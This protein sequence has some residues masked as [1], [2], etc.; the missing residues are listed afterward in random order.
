MSTFTAVI[1]YLVYVYFIPTTWFVY[2]IHH[3][4]HVMPLENGKK[5][6]GKNNLLLGFF[7]KIALGSSS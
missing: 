3:G 2:F 7:A 1:F 4:D 6:K 5:K